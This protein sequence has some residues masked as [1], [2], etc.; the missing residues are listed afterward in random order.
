M[1]ESHLH[2]AASPTITGHDVAGIGQVGNADGVEPGAHLGHPVA[3]AHAFHLASFQMP[4]GGE[5][6]GRHMRRQRG[7]ED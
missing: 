1:S 6:A 7:G 5:R 2:L 3:L 4:D